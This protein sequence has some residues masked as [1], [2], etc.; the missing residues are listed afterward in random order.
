M[1]LTGILD[2]GVVLLRRVDVPLEDGFSL[3]GCSR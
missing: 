1:P 2:G 3:L